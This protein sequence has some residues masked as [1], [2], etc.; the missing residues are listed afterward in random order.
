M[1]ERTTRQT[2]LFSATLSHRVL[3]LAY[4]HMNEPE[5]L[6][7]ETEHITAA[8]RAPEDLLPGRRRKDPA[9]DRPAVAQR[10]RAHDGVRQ[11]Q[12]VRRA[13]GACA[14]EGRLPGRRAS[15]DVP[16]KKR[17]TLLKRFQAGQLEIAGRHRCGRPRPAHRRRH[18]RLQLRPAVRCRGLRAPHRPYRAPGRR[19]RCD[20]LRLRALRAWAC[21]TS[22]PTSSRRSRSNTVTAEMLIA[23][24]RKPR[25]SVEADCRGR[26]EHRRDLQGSARSESR[27]GCQARRRPGR[28]GS[29]RR[30]FRS[31]IG[32]GFRRA[33]GAWSA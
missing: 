11:H 21:P 30:T 3:E 28:P 33:S 20:Q 25:E 22:R 32:L 24:P 19:R 5:K 17:E 13:R 10:R 1:P 29:Q 27:R 9:A 15:G 23:L 16:Q 26:R 2:L 12:G 14:G 6:V 8:A 4:E 18:A 31:A 7:V